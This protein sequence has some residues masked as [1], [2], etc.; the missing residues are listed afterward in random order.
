MAGN[1]LVDAISTLYCP[2]PYYWLVSIKS[3]EKNVF[4][5]DTNVLIPEIKRA[6]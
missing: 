5:S 1:K 4:I 6:N 3:I 2:V